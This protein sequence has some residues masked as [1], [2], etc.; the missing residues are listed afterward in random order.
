MSLIIHPF[1]LLMKE[2]PNVHVVDFIGYEPEWANFLR[3]SIYSGVCKLH[4]VLK[5]LL[6]RIDSSSNAAFYYDCAFHSRDSLKELYLTNK[7][8][9]I[10]DKLANLKGIVELTRLYIHEDIIHNIIDFSRMIGKYLPHHVTDIT[11]QF[12]KA[13]NSLTLVDSKSLLTAT[14][15]HS[16][17]RMKSASFAYYA[18]STDNEILFLMNRFTQIQDSS[19]TGFGNWNTQLWPTRISADV[20]VSFFKFLH[21]LK[22]YKISTNMDNDQQLLKIYCDAIRDFNNVNISNLLKYKH[23][24][25][26]EFGRKEISL[27]PLEE[28]DSRE[29]YNLAVTSTNDVHN[30]MHIIGMI[31][32]VSKKGERKEW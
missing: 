30:N 8:D 25:E 2:C 9:H 7:M 15:S 31:Y 11:V 27:A 19:I 21:S 32:C 20:M 6:H 14:S 18:P 10:E 5:G 4:S 16:V 1:Y 29:T 3:V 22:K 12:S 26:I 13:N 23:C 17:F 28:E 24:L